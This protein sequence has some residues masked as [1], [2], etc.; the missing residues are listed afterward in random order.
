MG[1]SFCF[2]EHDDAAAP[3]QGS[4]VERQAL[5]YNFSCP[6][7]RPWEN[8]AY[9]NRSR[10]E[11]LGRRRFSPDVCKLYHGRAF[12]SSF[13][14]KYGGNRTIYFLGESIAVQQFVSLACMLHGAAPGSWTAGKNGQGTNK[15]GWK[16]PNVL[17]K[18]CHGERRCHYQNACTRF[19]LGSE[20]LRLCVCSIV[21]LEEEMYRRCL[22]DNY[23]SPRDV[24][25]YGSIGVHYTGEGALHQD[26]FNVTRLASSEVGLLLPALG[27]HQTKARDGSSASWRPGARSPTL[28]W[29]E[30]LPQHFPAPG[31]HYWNGLSPMGSHYNVKRD[32]PGQC[33]SS[34]SLV[35]LYAHHRWNNVTVPIV[36]S[37]PGVR[38]LRIFH[39]SA[40]AW[41]AHLDY[42]D[43]THW[44]QPGVPD[45]W[46]ELLLSM[47]MARG[48]SR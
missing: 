11:A 7:L 45:H 8:C 25:V 13:L 21:V 38:V 29:R 2:A 23:P 35:E 14:E 27:F 1:K 44:C 16:T 28:I 48:V 19:A 30:V 20:R 36:E 34:H 26:T 4:W 47:L 42:G 33:D 12:M 3:L 31:G 9:D 39:S 15:F 32:V 18:R 22:K 46:T 24:V 43:C 40:V 37:V 5:P 10:A 41:D 6:F 17:K